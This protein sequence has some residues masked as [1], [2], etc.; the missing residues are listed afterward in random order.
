MKTNRIVQKIK[1]GN[2]AIALYLIISLLIIM[3][4]FVNQKVIASEISSDNI[5]T[6]YNTNTWPLS[7]RDY[8]R[9]EL[10]YG[11]RKIE[12]LEAKY[13]VNSI[14]PSNSKI[15]SGKFAYNI[16]SIAALLTVLPADSNAIETCI[17]AIK[18][19]TNYTSRQI[20]EF[21][22]KELEKNR[23]ITDSVKLLCE[24]IVSKSGNIEVKEADTEGCLFFQLLRTQGI[25]TAI[26]TK[27]IT[28]NKL[29]ILFALE[30]L[31]PINEPDEYVFSLTDIIL[32][33]FVRLEEE[34]K[35][36]GLNIVISSYVLTEEK[37]K[38]AELSEYM[39]F[40]GGNKLID[41][42]FNT[43]PHYVDNEGNVTYR[44]GTPGPN[45]GTATLAYA[46][47]LI[48]FRKE[49]F[50]AV[51]NGKLLDVFATQS[52]PP[53]KQKEDKSWLLFIYDSE[54]IQP[55]AK[56]Y[57]SGNLPA[58]YN[59]AEL[60]TILSGMLRYGDI[61]PEQIPSLSD[62]KVLVSLSV[63]S[64]ADEINNKMIRQPIGKQLNKEPNDL[65]D[66][67]F[68]K[69]TKLTL[70]DRSIS[71]ISMLAK[72]TNLQELTL[73]GVQ[74]NDIYSL[75][76]L[77]NLQTLYLNIAW[78]N[79]ISAIANFTQLQSL[80]ISSTR[81]FDLRLFSNLSNLKS[82]VIVSDRIIDVRSLAN[83]TNLQSLDLRCSQINHITS[84]AKLA[85]LRELIVN[86]TS[87][88]NDQLN[89]LKKALPNL[90]VNISYAR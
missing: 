26:Y 4:S 81:R 60:K 57:S 19:K 42:L 52:R 29:D 38:L 78:I 5:V 73:A 72:M 8:L 17:S 21:L 7:F 68:Q 43:I 13:L 3:L 28:N 82:L 88:I 37:R 12:Q 34:R 53:G 61:L 90:T 66:A 86:S 1:P 20:K 65:T 51:K 47:G 46:R 45:F 44:E 6:F 69:I 23:A 33:D 49:Y 36:A 79:D 75:A 71:D 31:K 18:S 14:F 48:Q 16:Q 54:L 2:T 58:G 87:V 10:L 83:L 30:S 25:T 56:I 32:K 22:N 39:S 55:L 84:L 80:G 50:E 63:S 40:S 41:M 77:P 64:K 59:K 74:I 11:D 62:V 27:L 76:K 9:L 24:E 85:N 15:E 35:L 67:D 89:D 70:S